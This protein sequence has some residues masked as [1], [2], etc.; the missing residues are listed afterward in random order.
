M[1]NRTEP[2]PFHPIA[3]I[4]PLLDGAEF[5]DLVTDI[6]KNGLLEPIV[7]LEDKI[8]DGRNRHRACIAAKVEPTFRPFNGDDPAA[9][10]ISTNI[11]RRHLTTE[12]K[13]KLIAKLVK[14]MPEKSDRQIGK[15]ARVSKNTA[16]KALGRKTA[17][18][19]GVERF[20]Q[21]DRTFAVTEADWNRDSYLLATPRGTV[22]LR[23][24][25]LRPANPDD[26]INKITAVGPSA[27][28]KCGR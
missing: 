19:S 6:K 3:D 21:A 8:L 2:I 12:Q 11:R 4:F 14:A 25:K 13:R 5:D 27:T 26:R 28:I 16:V 20:A 7:L 17:F 10:V 15:M 1:T 23:T 22:E 18:T 24:G 9:Y